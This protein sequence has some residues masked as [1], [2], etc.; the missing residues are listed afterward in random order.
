M[1]PYPDLVSHHVSSITGEPCCSRAVKAA[2][3]RGEMSECLKQFKTLRP[4][5][6]LV[7]T[8]CIPCLYVYHVT[9]S[10]IGPNTCAG[11]M[12]SNVTAQIRSA[13]RRR[14]QR[15]GASIQAKRG[16]LKDHG[17]NAKASILSLNL[18]WPLSAPV[19]SNRASGRQ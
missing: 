11:K 19:C 1:E 3:K 12:E 5:T 15:T 13:R 14:S 18:R 2:T 8:G 10:R 6:A 17:E 7:R 4:S 9:V 16:A